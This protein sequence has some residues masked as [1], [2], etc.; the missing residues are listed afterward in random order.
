MAPARALAAASSAPLPADL[1]A[2][3]E[4]S[5]SSASGANRTRTSMRMPGTSLVGGNGQLSGPLTLRPQLGVAGPQLSGGD[6]ARAHHPP[7]D[8]GKHYRRQARHQEA[9]AQVRVIER[10]Q[11]HPRRAQRGRGGEPETLQPGCREVSGDEHGRQRR[12]AADH[13]PDDQLVRERAEREGGCDRQ[14]GPALPGDRH[15]HQERE[16]GGQR[17]PMGIAG[18]RRGQPAD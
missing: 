4:I 9:R 18:H 11:R 17:S 13:R 1:L 2:G 14:R 12:T 7:G 5:I 10:L 16:H 15:R 3:P 6:G 8:A